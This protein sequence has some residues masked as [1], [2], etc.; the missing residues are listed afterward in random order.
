MYLILA[1]YGLNDV[2][3]FMKG[4][5]AFVLKNL[6]QVH[7]KRRLATPW[8]L[9]RNDKPAKLSAEID[10]LIEVADYS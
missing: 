2:G 10:M 1:N 7:T 3:L 9:I 6:Y 4:S 8:R 5:I